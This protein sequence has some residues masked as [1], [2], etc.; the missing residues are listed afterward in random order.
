MEFFE[1]H[2]FFAATTLLLI[3][4][5]ITLIFN[6]LSSK[7]GVFRYFVVHNKVGMSADDE[8]F[9]SVRLTWQGHDV[10]NLYLSTIEIENSTTSDYENIHLKVFTNQETV[11]LNQR[12]EIVDTP[13]IAPWD[14]QYERRIYVPDGESATPEQLDEYN[15]NRE[16]RLPVLNRG[17]KIRLSY[18]TSNPNDDNFPSVCVST[19]SKGIRLKQTI[20]PHLVLSPIFGVPVLVAIIRALFL[21]ILVILVC[22]LWLENVWLASSICII[23]GL[24]GQV[25]GAIAYKVERFVIELITG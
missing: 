24:S 4:A 14:A 23:F 15:H 3:G 8:V 11:L 21:S 25:F 6:K 7:T 1:Q 20:H 16:Y 10:R 12:S 2:Q 17:Q 18:L 19:L 9:G 13:Y 22:G 5:L